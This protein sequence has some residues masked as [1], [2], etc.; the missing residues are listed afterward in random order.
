MPRH[1]RPIKIRAQYAATIRESDRAKR[2]ARLNARRAHS[3]R[4]SMPTA[5]TV[6]DGR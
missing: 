5:P 6:K 4:Y 3:A 1:N 2:R